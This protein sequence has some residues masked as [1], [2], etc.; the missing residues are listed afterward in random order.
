M[1]FSDLNKLLSDAAEGALPKGYALPTSRPI[2]DDE[3]MEMTPEERKE[4]Q[5]FYSERSKKGD[6]NA[7][8][9]LGRTMTFDA[10]RIQKQREERSD[11]TKWPAFEEME[12]LGRTPEAKKRETEAPLMTFEPMDVVAQ[13]PNR[14]PL[15]RLSKQDAQSRQ[16]GFQY[17]PP[18]FSPTPAPVQPAPVQTAQ[19]NEFPEI[20]LTGEETPAP[21][22]DPV[23]VATKAA[24]AFQKSGSPSVA[25]IAPEFTQDSGID[26][27]GV[28][29]AQL[30]QQNEQ[31]ENETN[32]SLFQ[33][34]QNQML[35]EMEAKKRAE[36]QA[37]QAQLRSLLPI[38][39]GNLAEA[40]RQLATLKANPPASFRERV[41]QNAA[42]APVTA[43]QPDFTD[44]SMN[45]H[46][47]DLDALH[48]DTVETLKSRILRKQKVEEI[49][50]AL[51]EGKISQ[52]EAFSRLEDLAQ[53]DP[54]DLL[55]QFKAVG[56]VFQEQKLRDPNSSVN[57]QVRPED[58]NAQNLYY[59]TLNAFR[60]GAG[61][62]IEGAPTN[63]WVQAQ[64]NERDWT[65]GKGQMD[66]QQNKLDY[67][68]LQDAEANKLKAE[69]N[70][71]RAKNANTLASG[72]VSGAERAA[73]IQELGRVDTDISN[74]QKSFENDVATDIESIKKSGVPEADAIITANEKNEGRLYDL[75][76]RRNE[77]RSTLGY[78]VL[79]EV[80]VY[81][82][83]S[84]TFR[85]IK[86]AAGATPEPATPSQ[87]PVPAAQAPAQTVPAQTAP[88]TSPA[89]VQAP[90]QTAPKLPKKPIGDPNAP[91][92]PAPT[93]Q[94]VKDELNRR[95]FQVQ[96]QKRAKENSGLPAYAWADTTRPPAPDQKKKVSESKTLYDNMQGSIDTIRNSWKEFKAE[97]S[98]GLSADKEKLILLA[99]NVNQAVKLAQLDS[100]GD[101]F[102]KLGV[103]AGP[104]M[105]MIKGL[106]A[107]PIPSLKEDGALEQYAKQAF[108][109]GRA[110]DNQI[111]GL[112]KMITK[113]TSDF[114]KNNG[115]VYR[116]ALIPADGKGV[117]QYKEGEDALRMSRRS[118]AVENRGKPEE[119]VYVVSE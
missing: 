94:V 37:E 36:A 102:L 10:A 116:V 67:D 83:Q 87:L 57:R 71:I 85:K 15:P 20:D 47:T 99:D 16:S 117:T 103:L 12:V 24:E 25:A 21:Q 119:K 97:A 13:V 29:D 100:K 64:E 66:L 32:T 22:Q 91:K 5:T 109:G 35:R 115:V 11:T 114:A 2:S 33:Q 46:K 1:A 27:S 7:T 40:Q 93:G 39:E 96:L 3:L 72:K 58:V 56:D 61:M 108:T 26:L 107:T 6:E 8:K 84:K 76:Q 68:K 48:G 28:S 41:Q 69:A 98:K 55:N 45:A 63:P 19:V 88:V 65:K 34:R 86:N 81:D 17:T 49:G 60:A 51:S 111:D 113:R 77:L 75:Q 110:F 82:A 59:R 89:P 92:A 50:K 43:G 42:T 30:S 54:R 62:P 52:N 9:S 104:D 101:S 18:D 14:G 70:R 53:F 90:T 118:K 78:S 105:D 74:S 4:A 112:E 23:A 95:K 38:Q 31:L 106:I 79:P 73:L 80:T 44:D